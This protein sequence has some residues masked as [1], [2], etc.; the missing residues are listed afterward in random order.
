VRDHA[1]PQGGSR[2]SAGTENRSRI[3]VVSRKIRKPALR[4][5]L[6][7]HARDHLVGQVAALERRQASDRA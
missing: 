3:R 4:V 5:P 7:P 2:P 1:D 6:H